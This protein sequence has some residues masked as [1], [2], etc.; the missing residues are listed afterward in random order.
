MGMVAE[1]LSG[2]TDSCINLP[3]FTNFNL[4]KPAETK[5]T[6]EL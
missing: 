6:T 2:T 5:K 4:T 1:F 3:F